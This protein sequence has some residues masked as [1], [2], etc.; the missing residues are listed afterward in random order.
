MVHIYFI[1][2]LQVVVLIRRIEEST[3]P[4][5]EIA[6]DSFDDILVG[7]FEVIL[8]IVKRTARTASVTHPRLFLWLFFFG[9][10][11]RSP[12]NWLIL[13]LKS[14]ISAF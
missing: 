10:K 11:D 14:V 1:M 5:F 7:N 4:K 13:A 12:R 8:V 2:Y 9:E 6:C 3:R